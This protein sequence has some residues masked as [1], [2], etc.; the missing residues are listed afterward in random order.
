MYE[1]WN[2]GAVF[3]KRV[4]LQVDGTVQA[5]MHRHGGQPER[6][7]GEMLQVGE[8]SGSKLHYTLCSL[9]A[10]AHQKVFDIG[11]LRTY[12]VF[13]TEFGDEGQHKKRVVPEFEI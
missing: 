11:S 3:V 4:R 10:K 13:L 6:V 7:V 9:A 2:I 12:L 1:G 5:D 8:D